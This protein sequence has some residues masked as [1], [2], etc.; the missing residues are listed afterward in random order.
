MS[1]NEIF[2]VIFPVVASVATIL[3]VAQLIRTIQTGVWFFGGVGVHRAQNPR[4]FRHD[5]WLEGTV[6]LLMAVMA[7]LMWTLPREGRFDSSNAVL[8][9]SV[10][11]MGWVRTWSGN[12]LTRKQV[13][14]GYLL[15]VVAVA[16]VSLTL[17]RLVP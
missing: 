13:I 5:L 14:L 8:V 1:V 17:Q 15:L 7:V 6:V 12:R 2:H 9:W 4:A 11:F 16:G 10:A 3:P